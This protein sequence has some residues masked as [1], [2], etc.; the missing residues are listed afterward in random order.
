[1]SIAE[2]GCVMHIAEIVENP[3]QLDDVYVTD[4]IHNF[5]LT[6]PRAITELS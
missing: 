3:L 1:M 5:G 2:N 6:D 4:Y